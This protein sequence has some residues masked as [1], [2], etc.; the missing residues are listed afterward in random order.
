[1]IR[2]YFITALRN[3]SR[4]RIQSFIQIISLTIG[5]TIFSMVTLYLYDELTVDRLNEKHEQVY[6]IEAN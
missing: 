5:L 3:I 4:N 1:M 2:N 6:R